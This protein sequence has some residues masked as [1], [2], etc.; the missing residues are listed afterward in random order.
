MCAGAGK[1]GRGARLQPEGVAAH[2]LGGAAALLRHVGV[3]SPGGED[4]HGARQ[5]RRPVSPRRPQHQHARLRRNPT[6]RPSRGFHHREFSTP[7][8]PP[9]IQAWTLARATPSRHF[10]SRFHSASTAKSKGL[11]LPPHSAAQRCRH[12]FTSNYS[13]GFLQPIGCIDD[14]GAH[15]VQGNAHCHCCLDK[16]SMHAP[17][18]AEQHTRA[19]PTKPTA[20]IQRYSLMPWGIQAFPC[21]SNGLGT[22]PPSAPYAGCT[23]TLE[24]ARLASAPDPRCVYN[25]QG[26]AEDTDATDN[27]SPFYPKP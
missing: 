12:E 16:A 1:E 24:T 13:Q 22:G 19:S 26:P 2:E 15:R 7:R 5:P 8:A 3:A 17:V 18:F 21:D 23:C 25:A 20:T 9:T 27:A 11:G 14:P 4:R 6:S 10:P